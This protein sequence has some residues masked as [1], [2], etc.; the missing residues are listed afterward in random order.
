MG[1][2]AEER[3]ECRKRVY[4]GERWDMGGHQCGFKAQPGSEF[5][6]L[7]GGRTAEDP[8]R[9]AVSA[10]SVTGSAVT[11]FR[12]ELSWAD[13]GGPVVR[14]PYREGY[15]FIT[16]AVAKQVGNGRAE[17]EVRGQV[18]KAD[19]T[20]GVARWERGGERELGE[21]YTAILLGALRAQG[22]P[23]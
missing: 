7:H 8:T 2:E 11:T 14:I 6:H 10:P 20:P 5:C 4:S 13:G 12:A 1:A 15:G 18:R 16:Y 17:V 23:E 21:Q 22:A 19:G 9:E 3:P